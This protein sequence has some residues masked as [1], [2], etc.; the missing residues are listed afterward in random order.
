MAVNS[1]PDGIVQD[2]LIFY[3]D[4]ANKESYPGSGTT[5]TDLVGT[6]NG[7]IS[8]ATFTNVDAGAWDFDGVDDNIDFGDIGFYSP[9]ISIS[10][11]VY[12]SNNGHFIK[13]GSS[14]SN[15][16]LWVHVHNNT[17]LRIYIRN[18]F[19]VFSSCITLNQWHYITITRIDYNN[20]KVYVNGV[21]QGD[22]IGTFA[23]LSQTG[24]LV[25]CDSLLGN[26]ASYQIYNKAL[27]ASEVT[28][29]YNALKGRFV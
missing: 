14:G 20:G 23:D 22:L 18:V 29:N 8:G 17:D 4:A 12:P 2:G 13:Y 15:P 1:G 25:I 10:C 6:S 5:A 3:V 27:S 21:S 9:Q 28:Q 19:R 16:L 11:W 7:T 24:N 26:A